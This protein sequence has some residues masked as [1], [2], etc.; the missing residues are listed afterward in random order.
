MQYRGR[1]A[2][3]RAARQPGNPLGAALRQF[4]GALAL[5]LTSASDLWWYNRFSGLSAASQ[6]EAAL[7]FYGGLPC[8]IETWP[9]FETSELLSVLA[10]KGFAPFARS[11]TLYGQPSALPRVAGVETREVLDKRGQFDD[12]YLRAFGFDHPVQRAMTLLENQ[13]PG[14]RRY[15][16]FLGG[17]AVAAAVLIEYGGVAYLAGAATLPEFRQ[18]GAQSAL[19]ARRVADAGSGAL[20]AVTAT[21]GSGSQRNLER[22]GLRVAH[23]KTTWRSEGPA[24]GAT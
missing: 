22:L 21:L 3:E 18:L 4:E 16:A 6:L 2:F 23:V 19:V 20:V 5:K 10:E 17:E 12:L 9:M 24:Y 1:A 14:V 13:V 11:V 15:L 7:N 8:A